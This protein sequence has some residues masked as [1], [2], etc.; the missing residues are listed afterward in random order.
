MGTPCTLR[1][2][3]SQGH[4]KEISTTRG[5]LRARSNSNHLIP[6]NVR[7]PC[8]KRNHQVHFLL[9]A[10]VFAMLIAFATADI[11]CGSLVDDDPSWLLANDQSPGRE[12]DWCMAK[13]HE[14]PSYTSGIPSTRRRLGRKGKGKAKKK[15]GKRKA[16][17][18]KKRKASKPKKR[19]TPKKKSKP[20][21]KQQNHK[22]KGGKKQKKL[23]K[24][25][26]KK[27]A[28]KKK[29]KKK[30]QKKKNKNKAIR[31]QCTTCNAWF[32]SKTKLKKH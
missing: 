14:M 23:R 24:P 18:P 17:K 19:N 10:S 29:N 6:S 4:T 22:K 5:R 28:Q 31:S 7:Y 30:V 1:L 32:D 11:G 9:C 27:K 15:G 26:P 16:P 3:Q 13:E 21:K 20:K 8:S 12:R 2:T 25:Q